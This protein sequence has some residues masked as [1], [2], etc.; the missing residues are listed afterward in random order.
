MKTAF[1]TEMNFSGKIPRV[2]E[3]MR[4]E[5]AWMCATEADHY[6][7]NQLPKEYDL[8]VIIIPKKFGIELKWDA[9]INL[10]K[11]KNKKVAVM[12]EG[13]SWYFQDYNV[14]LQ[15][16]YFNALTAADIIF[17][18]N[19]NDYVYYKGLTNHKNVQILSSLMI[20]DSINTALLTLPENREKVI[21]GGNFVS[22]YGGFDSYMVASEIDEVWAPS[23]GRKQA[24]E[25]G[26]V[27]HLPYL[28]WTDWIRALSGFRIGIHLMRTYAA[29][30][31]ALNCAYLGIPCIGYKNLDTQRQCHPMLTIDEG[32][33]GR[34]KLLIKRL[35]EDKKFYNSCSKTCKSQYDLLFSERAFL[36]KWNTIT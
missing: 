20:E 13:P 35:D 27:K 14:T 5:F 1:I 24:G 22:W 12:Q 4:T 17:V 11:E 29:G 32:E 31:F 26:Y 10:L 28:N 15:I 6:V 19:Y 9:Y 30:T 2:H 18:H 16:E 7:I 8:V 25:E 33:I 36:N 23:M 34:A 3:N 21:I